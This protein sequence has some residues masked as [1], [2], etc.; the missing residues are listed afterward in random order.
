M[1]RTNG[2]ISL[3]LHLSS[4]F[5][6][7]LSLFNFHFQMGA[8][9]CRTLQEKEEYKL[10]P[11]HNSNQIEKINTSNIEKIYFGVK[12]K[13]NFSISLCVWK[14]VFVL[15]SSKSKT[16]QKRYVRQSRALQLQ[17][18]FLVLLGPT[19]KPHSPLFTLPHML[20]TPP[21][22]MTLNLRR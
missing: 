10:V 9:I 15:D 6:A 8:H 5:F 16:C 20:A 18:I 4:C 2:I 13:C 12:E 22:I 14:T 7:P 11:T 19:T 17:P 3:S 1:L 21:H